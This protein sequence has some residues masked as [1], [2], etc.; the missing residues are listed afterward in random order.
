LLLLLL[1]L[2]WQLTVPLTVPLLTWRCRH[3]SRHHR[4]PTDHQG[5]TQE[6]QE[7]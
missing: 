6:C 2:T 7:S 4:H 3:P 5:S 1:L